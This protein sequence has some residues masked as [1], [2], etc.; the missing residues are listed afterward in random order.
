MKTLIVSNGYGEDAI[1]A[2]IGRELKRLGVE[3]AALPLVGAGLSYQEQQIEALGPRQ[4]MPSGG[5]VFDRP[6]AFR[7]DLQAGFISM[8]L[9]QWQTLWQSSRRIQATLVVGD[10]YALSVARFFS[11][12]L[13]FQMQPLVSLHYWQG[14]GAPT[15]GQPYG[16]WERTLMQ[17]ATRVYPRDEATTT[18][19]QQHGVPQALYLGNPMLDALYG[20]DPVDL[21]APYLL[22]LPGS[23]ADAFESLPIMLGACYL[24]RELNLTPV[25]AWTGLPL[26]ADMGKWKLVTTGASEGITHY[27]E[28]AGHKVYVVQK[29]FA[30]L[31][32]NAKL[33]LSTSGT[34]AEQAAAYGV[35][36]IGFPT[37]GP[38]YTAPFA[39]GQKRLLREALTL[40]EARAE[41]IAK[42]ALALLKNAEAYSLAQEA[43]KVVMGEPGAAECIAKDIHYSLVKG[44]ANV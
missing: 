4:T 20:E 34:A 19:L 22:L 18:W 12:G 27:F 6:G 24:L 25:I 38:Q 14:E 26:T 37:S 1:G 31:L 7:K 39:L 21:P 11:R 15:W 33:A 8:T 44:D 30:S 3:V 36:L 29:R 17:A 41:K 28:H 23:R 16:V 35:P 10:W 40:V 42:A 9:R 32:K 5:F 2:A 43:G 13:L